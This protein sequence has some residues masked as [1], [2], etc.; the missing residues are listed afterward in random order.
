MTPMMGFYALLMGVVAVIA[1]GIYRP[2]GLI[3]EFKLQR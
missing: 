3:G 1:G 2:Q